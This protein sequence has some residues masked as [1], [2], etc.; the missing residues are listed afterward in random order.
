[1]FSLQ[2]A[3][4]SPWHGYDK[5]LMICQEAPSTAWHINEQVPTVSSSCAATQSSTIAAR[6][7]SDKSS[8]VARSMR[9]LS[10]CYL[11]FTLDSN[12]PYNIHPHI[13]L[14]GSY[15]VSMF[16]RSQSRIF[17]I[18]ARRVHC[19]KNT[20]NSS[21]WRL[22]QLSAMSIAAWRSAVPSPWP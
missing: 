5:S 3:R 18:N 1:M 9:C 6:V 2:P 10:I 7:S 14:P 22:S 21:R 4:G 20:V 13:V 15:D 12:E 19:R 16:P 8:V 11:K 17:C